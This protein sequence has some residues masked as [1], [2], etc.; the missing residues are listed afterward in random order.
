M[1]MIIIKLEVVMLIA[2]SIA[3][4]MLLKTITVV[5]IVMLFPFAGPC[6]VRV[7]RLHTPRICMIMIVIKM[8]IVTAVVM[9][10]QCHQQ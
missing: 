5:V 10:I 6:T 9:L 8:T 3:V 1:I 2:I 4:V 7:M